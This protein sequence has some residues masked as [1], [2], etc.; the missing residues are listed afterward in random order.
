MLKN[1]IVKPEIK[2]LGETAITAFLQAID[3]HR[4][5]SLYLVTLFTDA[6]HGE[7]LGLPWSVVDFDAPPGTV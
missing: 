7:V 4:R 1:W 3:A 2:P 6:R 5:D